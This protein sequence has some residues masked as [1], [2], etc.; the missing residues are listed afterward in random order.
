MSPW[1]QRK[2]IAYDQYNFYRF[3]CADSLEGSVPWKHAKLIND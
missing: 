3:L 2:F 1:V